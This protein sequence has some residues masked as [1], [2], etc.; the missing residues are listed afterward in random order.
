M[1]AHDPCASK[2]ETF[3][4]VEDRRPVHQ[5]R[6]GVRGRQRCRACRRGVRGVRGP[7]RGDPAADDTLAGVRLEPVDPGRL[8]G[9]PLPRSEEHTSELQSLMRSSYAVFCL[10]KKQYK[11]ND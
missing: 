10:K 11:N 1:R 4:K 5:S 7:G 2:L 9:E 6:E 8:V 3:R